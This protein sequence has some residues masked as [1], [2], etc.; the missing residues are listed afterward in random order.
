MITLQNIDFRKIELPKDKRILVVTDPPYNIG[1]KYGVHKDRMN[2]SEYIKMLAD[3][4]KPC[5]I[6][7]YPEE[8]LNYVIPAMGCNPDKV[9]FWCY[10]SH[11]PRA[12]RMISFF[13]IKPDLSK[14]KIPYRNPSD[15]RIKKLIDNGSEGTS[16][17]EWFVIEQV[18]NV[19]KEY[20]GY[21]NQIPEEV[22]RIILSISD[23]QFDTVF[24]PFCGSG[25]TLKVGIEKGYDVIGTDIDVNAIEISKKRLGVKSGY[26]AND[27]SIHSKTEVFGYPA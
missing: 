26:D 21:V 9:L 18:K 11:L 27:D 2:T 6:I 15:K 10:N 20:Q 25:T 1:F 22:I 24:D 8:T 7:H 12:V 5:V 19:S 13:G 23:G 3:I 14:Y 17:K 4:P 16:I